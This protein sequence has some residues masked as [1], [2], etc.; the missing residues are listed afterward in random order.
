MRKGGTAPD[1]PRGKSG[2]V[3]PFP[4]NRF[5]TLGQTD[6]GR[7]LFLVFTVRKNK[8]WVISARDMSRKER[9]IYQRHEKENTSIQK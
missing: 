9:G 3:P 2:A 5:Y 4:K 6:T 7:L 1:F 8:I